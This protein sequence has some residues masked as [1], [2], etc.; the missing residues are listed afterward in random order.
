MILINSIDLTKM[1]SFV[2]A[3]ELEQLAEIIYRARFKS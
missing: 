2:F 1:L 3:N